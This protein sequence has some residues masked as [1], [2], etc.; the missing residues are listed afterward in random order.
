MASCVIYVLS[1]GIFGF[2]NQYVYIAILAIFAEGLIL[3]I[4]KWSCPLTIVAKNYTQDREENFD[5]FLPR[6]LA[7][8]NK[9]IFTALFVAGIILIV[10]RVVF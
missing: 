2:I 9:V 8:H 7:K 5:I 1:A 4:F 3:L 6:F 10:L